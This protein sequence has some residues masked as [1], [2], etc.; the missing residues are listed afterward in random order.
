M[1]NKLKNKP[2]LLGALLAFLG[3]AFWG[4]SGVSGQ[5]LFSVKGV[6]STWLIPIRLTLAGVLLLAFQF[7]RNGKKTLDV[8]KNKRNAIDTVIYGMFGL[9]MCQYTYFQTIEWSNA[10]TA[11]VIQYLGPSL[12]VLV[13]CIMEKRRPKITEV[14]A[15][16]LAMAGIF[17]IATHGNPTTL[18]L[19]PRALGMG[20]LSA[21]AVVLYTLQPV[22]LLKQFN[23]MTVLAWGMLIGGIELMIIFRPWRYQVNI[24]AG[25]VAA[26]L[27]LIIFGTIISF[28][29]YMQSVKMI[30]GVKA[31]LIACIEPVSAT[32]FSALLL[33]TSFAP[34]DIVGFV[35][36]LSTI[37]I[38]A[39]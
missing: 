22:R 9:M 25:F 2:G 1:I 4:I 15:V 34:I 23:T 32:V 28:S 36:V 20:L 10:G 26:F 13:M 31:S 33:G 39:I 27:Y 6:T 7:A 38:S 19:S 8:W 35:L 16:L 5:Y 30:G 3:G 12:V 17:L 18:V 11:C 24:D 21:V 29:L 37:F 14:A